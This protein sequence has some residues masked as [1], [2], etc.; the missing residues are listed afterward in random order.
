M[1]RGLDIR[2][3]GNV[4]GTAF[5]GGLGIKTPSDQYS[6]ANLPGGQ[7]YPV[8]GLLES[9]QAPSE[10]FG[11]PTTQPTALEEAQRRAAEYNDPLNTIEAAAGHFYTGLQFG[12]RTP[13]VL[14]GVQERL[15]YTDDQMRSLGYMRTLA[16]WVRLPKGPKTA[17]TGTV[18]PGNSRQTVYVGGGG[19][20]G[21]RYSST[22]GSSLIN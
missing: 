21:S 20:G 1:R 22:P 12:T 11:F 6:Q 9:G 8:E 13:F 16:G 10:F 2:G 5:S 3:V 14:F 17:T 15:G 4:L 19:G 18:S 7:S